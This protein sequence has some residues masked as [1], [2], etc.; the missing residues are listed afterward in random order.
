MFKLRDILPLMDKD[1]PFVIIDQN[2][3]H[4]TVEP[5]RVGVAVKDIMDKPVTQIT[6][7][8][9]DAY[10]EEDF[11]ALRVAFNKEDIL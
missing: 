11:A 2:G 7:F 9:F 3:D 6:R 1:Q 4:I 5:G 10:A 8:R